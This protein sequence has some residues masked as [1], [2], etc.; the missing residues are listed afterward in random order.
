M[1]ILA[2]VLYMLFLGVLCFPLRRLLKKLPLHAECIPFRSFAFEKEGRFYDHI[3]IRRWKR[4]LPDISRLFPTFVP[5][6]KL[7]GEANET[8]LQSLLQESCIS[9]LIHWL[10]IAAG[11]ALFRIAPGYD[12]AVLYASYLVFGNLPFILIQRYNRPRLLRLLHRKE[13][14]PAGPRV[15]LLSC[16]M[17]G[18]H[19][20]V[21]NAIREDLSE[22]GCTCEIRDGLGFLSPIISRLA[23]WLH[24]LAYRRAPKLSAAFYR[25]AEKNRAQLRPGGFV[26]RCIGLRKGKLARFIR[27]GRFDAVIC[28][29]VIA[30]MILADAKQSYGLPVWTAIV[31]TD[32]TVTPG[33]EA[34]DL[35]AH[36]VPTET[37]KSRL[38]SLGVPQE[39]VTESGIPV[40]RAIRESV[41]KAAAK[42]TVGLSAEH[43]HVLLMCGSMGCGPVAETVE[44]LDALLD[45]SVEISVICGTNE[46]LRKTLGKLAAKSRRL[47]IYGRVEN[48]A[49]HLA[50]AELF[51]T[52][53]G[54]ISSTEGMQQAVPMLLVDAGCGCEQYNLQFFV[55]SGGAEAGR[56]AEELAKRAKELLEDAARRKE[57][58]AALIQLRGRYSQA[59]IAEAA[60]KAVFPAK[61]E[62][63]EKTSAVR[64]M[65]PMQSD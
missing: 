19:N 2:A 20:S 15:L 23:A 47:H 46:R 24:A 64:I 63:N 17:G 43:L 60:G 28:T 30:G 57:M 49:L 26:R 53:P 40:R 4:R 62:K 31:E 36:F 51:L 48:A 54:G 42:Q 45:E 12:G 61:A 18:G 56:S 10:L 58:S 38:V 37:L 41:Q 7:Q 1:Q 27:E 50:S 59:V 11:L 9:E 3:R 25:R 8:L 6:K 14:K 55:S 13:D 22:R 29:H 52:K 39:K 65:L 44:R 33:S 21:A 34:I 16:N 32:Y 5:E 35:D